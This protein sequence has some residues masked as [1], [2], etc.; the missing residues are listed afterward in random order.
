MAGRSRRVA[1]AESA[2]RGVDAAIAY[3]A[4]DSPAAAAKVLDA[5]MG[6]ASSLADLSE[7]GRIVPEVLDPSFREV[8]VFSYRLLYRVS[9]EEVTIVA[10]IHGARDF[11]RW[12]SEWGPGGASADPPPS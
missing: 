10:F 6:T 1:W 5:V 2:R 7:R 9:E 4:E 3:I 8:F 12:S 11:T